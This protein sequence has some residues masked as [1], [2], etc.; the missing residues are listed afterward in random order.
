MAQHMLNVGYL[1]L[2]FP[3]PTET[4]IA[5]EIKALRSQGIQVQVVSVLRPKSGP[6]SEDVEHLLRSS[7]YA[8][9][10]L[11]FRLLRG[12]IYYLFSSPR[13]Y[14]SLLRN[15]LRCPYPVHPP[16]LLAK[17][18]V[19]FLKAVSS[20]YQLRNTRIQLIHSHF[21]WLSGAAAWICSRLLSI[22][23]TVTVHAYDLFSSTDL[24]ELVCTEA[25]HVF[26]I[27]HH[28]RTVLTE[29]GLRPDE[30][31]S[32]VHCGV[33]LEEIDS[34]SR[35]LMPSSN[36]RSV[37]ILSVGSLIEKKGHPT[38]IEACR[39]LKDRGLDFTCTIVGGGGEE[40]D[41]Q[42]LIVLSGLQEQVALQGYRCH[43]D[44]LTAYGQHDVFA[45]ASCVARNGDRD[46]IP[47]VMM[48]AGA[49][50]MPLVSTQVS[51]IPEL[52][53]DQRTGLL[54]P[55][56]DSFALADAIGALVADPTLAEK[57]GQNARKLIESEFEIRAN[58]TQLVD[59]WSG[60]LSQ[61]EARV[62]H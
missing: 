41:L 19:I 61:A 24:L 59:L 11:S 32:V 6:P 52:V 33:N 3:H 8:P 56:G 25:A 36:G 46:G 57:L 45:L 17:R 37:R 43:P 53:I 12:N 14:F 21:A 42:R 58:A 49:F 28:N 20:A 10:L 54:V 48:E 34:R 5:E 60:I 51:G 13:L 50:G 47:V 1:L 2:R 35:A 30:S 44:V 62:P 38:L 7:S 31:I 55:P 40:A 9:N 22:P 23:F 4:F 18:I 27:S 39:I 16:L 15:L 26:A 29:M